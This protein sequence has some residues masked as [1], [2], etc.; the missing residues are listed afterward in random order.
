[1]SSSLARWTV[2][3]NFLRR[4]TTLTFNLFEELFFQV[5]PSFTSYYTL[6][7]PNPADFNKIIQ[8]LRH[9]QRF[10]PSYRDIQIDSSPSARGFVEGLPDHLLNRAQVSTSDIAAAVNDVADAAHVGTDHGDLEGTHVQLQAVLL[11][12]TGAPEET[13]REAIVGALSLASRSARSLHAGAEMPFEPS[14]DA[15]LHRPQDPPAPL[16]TSFAPSVPDRPPPVPLL[17]LLLATPPSLL[18]LGLGLLLSK[19]GMMQLLSM[20]LLTCNS[21]WRGLPEHLPPRLP[22]EPCWTNVQGREEAPPLS[23]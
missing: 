10:I 21:S 11:E 3:A 12:P 18:L 7:D 23:G 13:E 9:C 2:G 17:F 6:S 16:S 4:E 15:V 5:H 19:S 8:F 14:E 22:L 1:M 20:S